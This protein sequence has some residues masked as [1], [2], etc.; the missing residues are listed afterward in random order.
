MRLFTNPAFEDLLWPLTDAEYTLL[1][2]AIKTVGCRDPICVTGSIIVDGHNRYDICKE[3]GVTFTT[4]SMS[5]PNEQAVK[6]WI[7]IN[8][9]GKRNLTD[10]QLRIVRGRT[11]NRLKQTHGGQLPKGL[12]QNG[13]SLSTAEKVSKEFGVSERTIHRDAKFAEEVEKS[14]ELQD[15][16]RNKVPVKKAK[17]ELYKASE[18]KK[19][20]TSSIIVTPD[21]GTYYNCDLAVAPIADNSLDVIITDPPYHREFLSCWNKLAEFAVSKLK[22]GGVLIAMSGQSYL[23]EV[24]SAMTIDGLNYHWTCCNYAPKVRTDCHAK[25]LFTEWKPLLVYVKGKYTRTHHGTDV[26]ISDYE[27]TQKGQSHHKWGQSEKLFDKLVKD[28]TYAGELVCD[29][30]LG[31]GT[32]AVACKLNKRTNFI[33]VEIDKKVLS[34][35]KARIQEA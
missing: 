20:D 4:S 28:W 3:H 12:C 23:P 13:I 2:D 8:Q 17:N 11:Y 35:A 29:P 9:L 7:D 33:G 18:H 30:F 21:F 6:D 31:G 16:V 25:R 19:K 5:F 15:A 10:E 1:E 32:T 34:A 26:F 14:P 27:D 22:V 24:Y